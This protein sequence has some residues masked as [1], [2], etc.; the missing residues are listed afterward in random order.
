MDSNFWINKW[1]RGETR[2]HQSQYHSLLVKYGDK[3]TKGTILVPLCGK[4]LDMLYLA[5]K[6]HSVIG[7]ELSPIA[8]KDFFEEEGIEYT[9]VSVQDF[10][11]FESDKITLWCGDFFKLPQAVW[12]KVTG[13][14]D[15]AALIALPEDIR[16]LYAA[17]FF[18]RSTKQ[19]E[20]LLITLEYLKDSFQGP[21]FSVEEDEVKGIY[22]P[23]NIQKIHSEKEGK[24]TKDKSIE[25]TENVYWMEKGQY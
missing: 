2:F 5:S 18:K 23:L 14:Y 15:R 19:I 6:G 21:P 17:E 8:C 16:K 13:V 12:D 1:E 24:L 7:V 22:G 25:I 4:S 11:V 10:I 3:L 20:I 9:T